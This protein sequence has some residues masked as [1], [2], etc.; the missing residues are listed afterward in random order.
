M[1]NKYYLTLYNIHTLIN[2]YGFQYRWLDI[3]KESFYNYTKA[4][5]KH[6][7][8]GNLYLNEIQ[9]DK[10]KMGEDILQRGMYCP[11]FYYIKN[12]QNLLFLGKHRLHALLTYYKTNKFNKKFLFLEYYTDPREAKKDSIEIPNDFP[13]LYTWEKETYFKF[14]PKTYYDLNILI[15]ANGD[16]LSNWL[17]ENHIQPS[18]IINDEKLFEDFINKP[19]NLPLKMK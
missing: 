13:C 5:Y 17:Y 8:M 19:F 11:F 10:I 4:S 6:T 7:P 18:S 3:S 9:D 15:M 12:N 14:K 2:Y 16:D 1:Y